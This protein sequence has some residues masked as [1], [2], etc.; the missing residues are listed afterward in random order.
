MRPVAP[1]ET[2]HSPQEAFIFFSPSLF[3]FR[4][5]HRIKPSCAPFLQQPFFVSAA[6]SPS[7]LLSPASFL[8]LYYNFDPRPGQ[9]RASILMLRSQILISSLV[10][11]LLKT[12][13]PSD[14]E[15]R[16]SFWMT[17]YLPLLCALFLFL[18]RYYT[19]Q[20]IRHSRS[21]PAF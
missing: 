21:F 18:E 17:R 10:S 12:I 16:F 14:I 5:L 7:F 19:R 4:W 11:G 13:S 6:S 3:Y 20:T 9:H 1:R 15:G 8:L 2:H